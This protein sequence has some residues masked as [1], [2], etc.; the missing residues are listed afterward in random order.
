MN[1]PFGLANLSVELET[2]RDAA[3]G[4]KIKP[5]GKGP[6]PIM[7]QLPLGPD[8]HGHEGG[9]EPQP[10]QNALLGMI[11]FLGTDFMFFAALIGAFLVFRLGSTDWPPPGQPR[12]P[13][14]VTGANTAILLASGLT[15]Y[16]ALRSRRQREQREQR[17]WLTVTAILGATFL[18][19]QGSEWIRL[20]GFGLT[21]SSSV[22]GSIFYTLIGCHAVHV[23]GAVIWLLI[24][25]LL[26]RRG[27]F[28]AKPGVALQL[29]GM[30]WFLVVALWPILYVLVYLN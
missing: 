10:V 5:N 19:V 18:A 8:D 26:A 30:Y 13:L 28:E 7:P 3:A 11:L 16:R 2:G 24:V 22:Y 4:I 23:L 25:M 29:A 15:M 1:L 14:L 12:L 9:A 6:P 27:H 17:R 21:M 20:V